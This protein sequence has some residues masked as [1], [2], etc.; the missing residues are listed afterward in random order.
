MKSVCLAGLGFTSKTRHGFILPLTVLALT[1]VAFFLMY[2]SKLSSGYVSQVAHEDDILRCRTIAESV[3]NN[4]LG[5]IRQNP[6]KQRFFSPKP[7]GEINQPLF[8]GVYT[9]YV[10]DVPGKINEADIY[11]ESRFGRVRR[12][13][14]WR[15]KFEFSIL[16]CTGHLSSIL[17]TSRNTNTFVPP[18]TGSP[19][20]SFIDGILSDR[21]VNQEKSNEKAGVI[22]TL[23]SL[24]DV[25]KVLDGP[26]DPGAV[27]GSYPAVIPVIPPIVTP[28]ASSTWTTLVNDDFES[29]PI[30]S[31]PPNFQ[32]IVTQGGWT[33]LPA[34]IL[35]FS[36]T[37][38]LSF[39]DAKAM[40]VWE[41]PQKLGDFSELKIE[42]QTQI[43]SKGDYYGAEL[44]KMG[45]TH[46]ILLNM[47]SYGNFTNPL[48]TFANRKIV[49]LY[50]LKNHTATINYYEGAQETQVLKDVP[51]ES[52]APDEKIRFFV[53]P[54]LFSEFDFRPIVAI[55][56]LKIM[57]R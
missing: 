46:K 52:F 50:N 4:V 29:Y 14:I 18:S 17:F 6:W 34:K 56:S 51:M 43:M 57:T 49:F 38:F 41:L 33:R 20:Q 1:S 45:L 9:L 10:T 35:T 44:F 32:E 24:I 5:R 12:F 22:K 8:G 21:S 13:F 48:R 42:C 36:G 40:G 26:N 25:T 27:T 28:T 54:S 47:I 19:Q 30:K 15:Y 39:F 31:V 3:V 55:D 23:S 7:F 53:L 2:V 37:K 11:I 16:D